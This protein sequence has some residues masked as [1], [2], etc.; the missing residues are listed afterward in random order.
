MV[1]IKHTRSKTDGGY[2][3]RITM[4]RD[5]HGKQIVRSTMWYPNPEQ[6]NNKQ[7]AE[8]LQEAVVLFRM[9]CKSKRFTDNTIKFE[10]LAEEW[11]N[12]AKSSLSPITFDTYRRIAPRIYKEF[13]YMQ[14][15][16]ITARQIQF[17]ID[18][19]MTNGRSKQKSKVAGK[20]L[21]RKRKQLHLGFI[22]NVFKRALRFDMVDRNPCSQVE[23][24]TER[25]KRKE[26]YTIEE[27]GQ[28]LVALESTDNIV[29]RMLINLMAHT[30][31]RRGELLG[32]EWRDVDLDYG[33][34]TIR[35]AVK[36]TKSIGT[37]VGET[38]TEESQRTIA[39][40]P[41]HIV[42]MLC[43]YKSWQNE[44]KL[45]LANKWINT[46]YDMVF[47]S[48]NGNLLCP[49]LPY[50]W[51]KDFCICNG[52]RFCDLHSLRHL[53]AS[54]LLQAGVDIVTVSRLLGHT[55]VS[56]T[57]NCYGHRNTASRNCEILSNAYR[58][59]SQTI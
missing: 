19:L 58:Q 13:G 30:G 21:S 14:I 20:P 52:F 31:V 24:P 4:G 51:F 42:D 28:I 2:E 36:Y 55:S 7:I 53:A 17:F 26:I 25:K 35:Q 57:L 46:G 34:I 39:G 45:Q 41:K 6:R 9:E 44:Q 49:T 5:I 27:M 40:L 8:A 33:S 29:L 15:G 37:H 48:W 43:N 56:T 18:S 32:L 23:L 16:E 59:A 1:K 12:G 3:I 22:S 54:T 11:L 50:K 47:S 10:A 38:K